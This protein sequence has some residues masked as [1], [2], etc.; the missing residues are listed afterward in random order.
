MSDFCEI[1]G[2]N[3]RES[4]DGEPVIQ[5]IVRIVRQD[6]GNAPSGRACCGS[7]DF[8]EKASPEVRLA[9]QL[10]RRGTENLCR[11]CR[12]NLRAKLNALSAR[13]S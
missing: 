11:V 2:R 6:K 12:E 3:C 10:S 4:I 7:D 8:P 5:S 13:L 1:K 9:E